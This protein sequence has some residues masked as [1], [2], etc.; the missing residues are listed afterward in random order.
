MKRSRSSPC[1]RNLCRTI[2][3]AATRAGTRRS[4]V[5]WSSG[6]CRPRTSQ[7]EQRDRTC[8]QWWFSQ[9]CFSSPLSTAIKLKLYK[10]MPFFFCEIPVTWQIALFREG[11]FYWQQTQCHFVACSP[12]CVKCIQCT[13][14]H[15]RWVQLLY[16]SPISQAKAG[17]RIWKFPAIYEQTF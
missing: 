16:S 17:T 6:A 11:I 10:P 14:G 5:C 15:P 4:P 13:S 8:Q 3:S 2:W 12:A 7:S 9:I 1:Y